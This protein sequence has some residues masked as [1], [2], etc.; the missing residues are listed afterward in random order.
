MLAAAVH[1]IHESPALCTICLQTCS[2]SSMMRSV[3]WCPKLNLKPGSSPIVWGAGSDGT[4]TSSGA[5]GIACHAAR[6]VQGGEEREREQGSVDAP[7]KPGSAALRAAKISL[8]S[9]FTWYKAANRS[10]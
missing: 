10:E 1:V 2:S 6:N 9:C 5:A 8:R 4:F 7:H 3:S